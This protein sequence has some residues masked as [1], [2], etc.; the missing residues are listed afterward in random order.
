MKILVLDIE[1]RPNMAYVWGL[2]DQNVGLNQIIETGTVISFAAKWYGKK[3]VHFYSDYHDGHE[4]MVKAAWDM[5]NEADAVVHFNGKAFDIKHLNREFILAGL[6]PPSP[7]KDIDLLSVVKQRFKFASNKLQHVS[8][9]LGIG[10][11]LQHD[12]FDLWL[13]CMADD[14]KAWNTMRRYNK[15]DVV[16]TEKVYERLR[17]W[18]KTHPNVALNTGRPDAC[19]TCASEHLQARGT[20]STNIAIYQR[21][22]CQSCG[23]WFRSS[24]RLIDQTSD[25]RNA[26]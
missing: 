13:R 16:L 12:G 24:K 5:L 10:S 18:I 11:K 25:I 20:A 4:T 2:W 19:P 7:H 17:P 26:G 8:S 1:T 15:Q 6:T 14:D 3:K 9:E 21:W 22:Q 23:G